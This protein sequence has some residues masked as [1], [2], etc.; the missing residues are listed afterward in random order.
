[1]SSISIQPG[2]YGLSGIHKFLAVVSTMQSAALDIAITK[3]MTG[4]WQVKRMTVDCDP[5]YNNEVEVC[6][7]AK[8]NGLKLEDVDSMTAAKLR[9]AGVRI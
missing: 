3:G 8:R 6:E 2:E 5:R 9:A 1:M 4:G 7:A